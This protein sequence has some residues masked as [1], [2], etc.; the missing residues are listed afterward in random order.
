MDVDERFWDLQLAGKQTEAGKK[1]NLIVIVVVA[2][3][4]D[5]DDVSLNVYVEFSLILFACASFGLAVQSMEKSDKHFLYFNSRSVLA[6]WYRYSF[7]ARES[8][9][10]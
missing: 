2:A 10:F 1:D 8:L 6:N 7:C 3:A 9:I 4:D 5:D